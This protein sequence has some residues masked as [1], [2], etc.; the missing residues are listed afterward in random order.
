MGVVEEPVADGVGERGLA[1]EVVPL[2]R[3]ML[4]RDDRGA[5]A[6]AILEDLEEVATLLI[7]GR[8]QAPVLEVE[9]IETRELAQEPAVRAVGVGQAQVLE[10]ARDAAVVGA[11]AVAARLGASAQATKLLPVPVAPVTRIC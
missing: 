6:I 9:D 2:G 8:G 4:A 3:R 10:Q 11:V 1:D 7:L 5:A